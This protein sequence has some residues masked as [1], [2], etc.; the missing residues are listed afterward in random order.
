MTRVS[1][2]PSPQVRR[3]VWSVAAVGVAM[4]WLLLL[5]TDIETA[6]ADFSSGRNR[7]H[8]AFSLVASVVSG[9]VIVSRSRTT[10]SAGCC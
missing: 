10:W 9:A 4:T 8:H 5:T 2:R 7:Y 6:G 1:G 3:L